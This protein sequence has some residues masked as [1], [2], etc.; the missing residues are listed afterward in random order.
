LPHCIRNHQN[1]SSDQMS[2]I[3]MIRSL[4]DNKQESEKKLFRRIEF[5]HNIRD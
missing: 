2:E 4:Y 1:V 3:F 5:H